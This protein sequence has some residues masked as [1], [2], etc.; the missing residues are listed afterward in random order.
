MSVGWVYVQFLLKAY[1][2]GGLDAII[3]TSQHLVW[4]WVMGRCTGLKDD[5]ISLNPL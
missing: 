4:Y 1:Y 2:K 5:L 3:H